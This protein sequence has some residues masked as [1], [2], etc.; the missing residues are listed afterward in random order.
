MQVQVYRNSGSF[1]TINCD[2]QRT[3]VN[4]VAVVFAVAPTSNQF[5]V[6]VLG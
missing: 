3:S 2:V 6:V 5:R 1:D 4:A